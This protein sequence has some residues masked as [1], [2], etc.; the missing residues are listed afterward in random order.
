GGADRGRR[1]APTGMHDIEILRRPFMA[2]PLDRRGLLR[3]SLFSAGVAAPLMLFGG[4]GAAQ[5][6][7]QAGDVSDADITS[8][9]NGGPAAGAARAGV[10]TPHATQTGVQFTGTLSALTSGRWFTFNWPAS[11]HVIWYAVSTSPSSGVIQVDSS[12]AVERSS[13]D[14]ITYWITIRN[15]SNAAINVEGRFSILNQ[16]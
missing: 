3:G 15:L 13:V 2:S 9:R 14:Y 12:W 7:P 10:V 11:W 1:E 8:A 16:G 6:S 5:A 4:V